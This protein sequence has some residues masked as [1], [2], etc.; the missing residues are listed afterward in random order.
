MGVGEQQ[1]LEA[2]GKIE[3][4]RG[5]LYLGADGQPRT[6]S[7]GQLTFVRFVLTALANAGPASVFVIDEPE[8]F[9]HPNLVSRF[10]RVL[11]RVLT[12]T[13]SIAIVATHSP[14]VVREVQS[15]QVHIMKALGDGTIRIAKPLLQTLGSNVASISNEVFGDD[16]PNHLYEELLTQAK[17]EDL[18]FEKVL[19][20]YANDLSHRK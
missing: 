9:L 4:S 8:N 16:L 20:K 7:L 18:V 11:H 6:P 1:L 13:T 17:T 2:V 10:M 19:D 12:S 14:F 3:H 15:A 5:L